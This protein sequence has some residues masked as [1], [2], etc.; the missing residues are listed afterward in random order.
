MVV[1]VERTATVTPQ[2]ETV[3]VLFLTVRGIAFTY[4]GYMRCMEKL[5]KV[6]SDFVEA[7]PIF[8]R[9]KERPFVLDFVYKNHAIIRNRQAFLTVVA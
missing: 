2:G 9:M 1:K 8:E 7:K 6:Y 3:A 5:L 4:F